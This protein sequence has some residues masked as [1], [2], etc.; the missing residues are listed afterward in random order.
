MATISSVV[1]EGDFAEGRVM[2]RML[3]LSPAKA[4]GSREGLP[5]AGCDSKRRRIVLGDLFER[6]EGGVAAE[7]PPK[8]RV[9]EMP[10]QARQVA[11]VETG[12][13]KI[14]TRWDGGEIVW[15]V[16]GEG[17]PLVLLHGDFGSWT[18]WIRNV[19]PL[20]KRFRVIVP[21]MPGYGD[22]APPPTDWTPGSLALILSRCLGDVVPAPERY[23]LAG[24][25]FGGIIA[26]HLA[27]HD[28]DRVETLVLA[29][30]GGF[31]QPYPSLPPL[32]RLSP[33]MADDEI[34]AV[35][36][37]NLAALMIADPARANDL[38]VHV[39]IE[40]VRRAR[41]RAGDIPTSDVLIRVL[42]QVRARLGGIWGERD[43][44]SGDGI[45]DREWMLRRIQPD[46]DFRL[47]PGAG[48]WAP[49]EAPEPICAALTA[50]VGR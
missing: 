47:I 7:R 26:G 44:M 25:S 39:Q 42:P 5:C 50:M 23:A 13:E 18:H 3:R 9:P 21:D 27:V 46:L 10:L 19:L 24:F 36:R 15:R 45:A 30:A 40:N 33:E 38:A 22:S 17:A 48:H 37:H 1:A 11:C 31:G 6:E 35:H 14:R 49:F 12:A 4:S 28:G 34:V 43:A 32:R 20:A 41:I 8:A 16:W 29:G 2:V